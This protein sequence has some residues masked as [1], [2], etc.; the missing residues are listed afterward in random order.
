LHPGQK[1]TLIVPGGGGYGD[2][3]Q[4]DRQAVAA[5]VAAGYVSPEQAERVYGFVGSDG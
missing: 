1:L 2:P 3:R 4:R 5:D